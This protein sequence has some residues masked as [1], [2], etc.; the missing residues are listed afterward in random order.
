MTQFLPTSSFQAAGFA[1]F[2]ISLCCIPPLVILGKLK[3][4]E[5][6]VFALLMYVLVCCWAFLP[7]SRPLYS[8]IASRPYFVLGFSLG[9]V[10]FM[11]FR[12]LQKR[13]RTA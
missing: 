13:S 8:F 7:S 6:K 2:E 5:R 10:A 3:L 4:T 12:K 11:L 9:M 1:L